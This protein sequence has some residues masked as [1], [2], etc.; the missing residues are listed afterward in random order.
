MIFILLFSHI[1]WFFVDAQTTPETPE[2]SD[3][4]CFSTPPN[5]SEFIG[6]SNK[7]LNA[8]IYVEEKNSIDVP[9]WVWQWGTYSIDQRISDARRKNNPNILEKMLDGATEDWNKKLSW[10]TTTAILVA[11]QVKSTAFDGITWLLWIFSQPRPIIRD[12]KR[13]YEIDRTLWERIDTLWLAGNYFEALQPDVYTEIAKIFAQYNWDNHIFSS[14]EIKKWAT[15]ANVVALLLNLNE[16]HKA[17]L[18]VWGI[19]RFGDLDQIKKMT[20]G[21]IELEIN[22]LHGTRL[23]DDYDGARH[24]ICNTSFKEFKK[25]MEEL[26]DSFGGGIEK[27]IVR[28]K[29]AVLRLGAVNFKSDTKDSGKK[30]KEYLDRENELL[31]TLY[32]LDVKKNKEGTNWEANIDENWASVQWWVWLAALRRWGVN[33]TKKDPKTIKEEKEMREKLRE[34]RKQARS[35]NQSL[36]AQQRA[37]SK[38]IRE[39]AAQE[40]KDKR[41]AKPNNIY[42]SPTEWDLVADMSNLMDNIILLHEQSMALMFQ[43]QVTDLTDQ[44]WEIVSKVSVARTM[45]KADEWDEDLVN[46]LG[47]ACELQC[48]NLGWKCRDD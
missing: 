23:K 34:S 4:A 33:K 44:V 20:K 13:L 27:E 22:P 41:S 42:I 35:E 21:T 14:I 3:E 16:K 10:I 37:D 12:L 46:Y 40:L 43:A 48:S 29:D 30:E 9:L 28:M 15:Y 36:L 39:L 26:I 17:F 32:W 45:I 11:T 47:K 18:A 24:Y 1:S 6:F 19:E 31:K 7:V 2:Y 25:N 5:M 38:L 8:L